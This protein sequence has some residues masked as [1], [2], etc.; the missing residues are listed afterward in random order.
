MNVKHFS[1]YADLLA[2]TLK[3]PPF[4]VYTELTREDDP[5]AQYRPVFQRPRLID[6]PKVIERIMQRREE[7]NLAF[8]YPPREEKPAAPVRGT[9]SFRGS[10]KL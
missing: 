7:L 1:A 8:P 6:D 3:R 5:K 2:K 10:R 4:G 9:G